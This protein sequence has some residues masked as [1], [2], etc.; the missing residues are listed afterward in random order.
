MNI[1]LAGNIAED[2]EAA[3]NCAVRAFPLGVA[4][5]VVLTVEPVADLDEC[6]FV[7]LLRP[8]PN[9]VLKMLI[10]GRTFRSVLRA[11]P[12]SAAEKQEDYENSRH[13]LVVLCVPSNA[14]NHRMA[15]D[16]ER[17]G[18]AFGS[19][20]AFALLGSF[21][22]LRAIKSLVHCL[23]ALTLNLFLLLDYVLNRRNVGI[24]SLQ[25]TVVVE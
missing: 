19:P 17:S 5:D 10:A 14:A 4:D 16:A 9:K 22:S 18:A 8:A 3:A 15:K 6:L 21:H 2:A 13:V 20:S 24:K 23:N 7:S 25:I 11:S 12:I 1:P